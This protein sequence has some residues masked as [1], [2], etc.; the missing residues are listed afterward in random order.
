[1]STPLPVNWLSFTAQKSNNTQ[2]SLQWSTA[3]ETK[4]HFYIVERSTDG[5]TFNSIGKL[6]G[7]NN[8]NMLQQ[9][10]YNDLKPYAGTN[11]YRLK[12]VDL[13][14]QFTYSSVA[15]VTLDRS[16]QTW[17]IYPNPAHGQSNIRLLDNM[18][19]VNI[20]LTD[21]S[22][23]IVYRTYLPSAK[24]GQQITLPL[25]GLAKGIYIIK[26]ETETESRSDKIVVQ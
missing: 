10:Y 15:K 26:M 13:D 17:T 3:N 16:G 14:G 7:G 18:K 20:A 23:K 5:V 2:V 22:G 6:A 4:N 8:L 9:Y 19:K 24:V 12:Q 25:Q 11:F 1:M 21:A